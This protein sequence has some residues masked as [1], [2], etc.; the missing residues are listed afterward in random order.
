MPATEMDPRLTPANG[1]VAAVELKGRVEAERF[2]DGERLQCVAPSADIRVCPDGGLASQLTYGETIRVF[3]TRQGWSF[4]QSESDG[5]VGYVPEDSLGPASLPTH[6]VF[7][8]K[9]HAY[10]EPSFKSIPARVFPFGSKLSATA[11]EGSFVEVR[12]GGYVPKGQL[13]DL[14]DFVSDFVATAET[15]IGVPYLWGGKGPDGV[16][17]SGLVQIA[18][19]SAGHSC[20]RDSDMQEAALGDPLSFHDEL[21]RGDLMFWT[22]HVGIMADADTL[23]HANASHMAVVKENFR[24]AESRIYANE[25][26]QVRAVRRL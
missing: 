7:R 3:E 14:D 21:I 19:H 5:Y 10:P 22:G 9:A 1:R 23:L 4:G 24:Q 13:L 18:L 11:E 26:L 25:S 20:P 16:D 2:V 8:L 6:R 12:G 15:F 17:C